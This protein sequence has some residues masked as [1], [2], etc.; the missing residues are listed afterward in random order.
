MEVQIT[1]KSDILKKY[2]DVKMKFS[3]YFKCVFYYEGRRNGLDITASI[4]GNPD[5][6]YEWDIDTKPI[7]LH[8][9]DDCYGVNRITLYKDKVK[10]EESQDDYI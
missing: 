4:G 9:L 2:G 1:P 5:D 6:I 7:T 8:K 10:V 3:G